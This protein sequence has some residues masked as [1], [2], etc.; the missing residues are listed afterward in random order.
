MAIGLFM[1]LYPNL[2]LELFRRAC[3]RSN[4]GRSFL[5]GLSGVNTN[6]SREGSDGIDRFQAFVYSLFH[7]A[8][9]M[10]TPAPRG[11]A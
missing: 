9:L 11:D 1:G 6:K 2:L 10:A 3:P 7:R 4:A 5:Y 8:S